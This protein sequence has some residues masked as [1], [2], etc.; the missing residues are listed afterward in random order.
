MYT[1]S[2]RIIDL[3]VGE[4][5]SILQKYQQPTKEEQPT[6]IIR[7]LRN[8]AKILGISQKTLQRWRA[9]RIITAP[10]IQQIHGV[11]I[12]DKYALLNFKITNK[13]KQHY[14]C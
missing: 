11:I 2:T 8:I 12:A 10:I 13:N 7:G 5:E 1:S 6:E 9:E 14:G 4:L 3:T